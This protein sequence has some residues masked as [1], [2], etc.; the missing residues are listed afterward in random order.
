MRRHGL[1]CRDRARLLGD[2]VMFQAGA[3]LLESHGYH[4]NHFAHFARPGD[5]NLYYRYGL[6]G[7]D[8]LA[9]GSSADG[10][11]GDEF[12]RHPELGDYLEG[13]GSGTPPLEGGGA[14]SA[15]DERSRSLLSQLMTAEIP[16]KGPLAPG[17]IAILERWCEAGLFQYDRAVKAWRLTNVGSWFISDCIA[18][19]AQ[20]D[21]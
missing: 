13:A 11:F 6:R 3:H 17:E 14:F 19:L 10:V 18:E 2:Y 1:G 12:Y 15:A 21:P 7:E 9:L 20:E 5:A 4:K 8:L 16:D